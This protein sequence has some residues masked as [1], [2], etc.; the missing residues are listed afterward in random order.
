MAVVFTPNPKAVLDLLWQGKPDQAEKLVIDEVARLRS[1]LTDT[2]QSI[3]EWEKLLPPKPSGLTVA[4]MAATNP[5]PVGGTG[6][7]GTNA[8]SGSFELSPSDK[9]KRL[10]HVLGVAKALALQDKEGLVSTGEVAKKLAAQGYDLQV[11]A[12]RV[13]TALGNM[14]IRSP[15]FKGVHKGVYRLIPAGAKRDF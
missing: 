4:L 1:V 14:I 9:R 8:Q 5:L 11:P 2:Q 6:F 3:L 15:E 13:N 7:K 12:G 10:G